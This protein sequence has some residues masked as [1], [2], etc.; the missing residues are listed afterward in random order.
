MGKETGMASGAYKEIELIERHIKM[1]HV[2]K[3]NQP[4]GIIRLSEILDLPRH[5]V[6]YSLRV[7]END[8]AI[9]ATPDGAMVSEKYD[10]FMKEMSDYLTKLVDRI[11]EV[12]SQ[13][14]GT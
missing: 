14:P 7:L 13:I 10:V 6:R 5:K 8:G 2:T 9:I 1:L 11:E 3:K 4:V 12:R